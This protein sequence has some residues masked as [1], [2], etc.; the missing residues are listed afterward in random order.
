MAKVE[1]I[2]GELDVT[3]D[4][5]RLFPRA[6]VPSREMK[7]LIKALAKVRQMTD[8]LDNIHLVDPALESGVMY[9]ILD[10]MGDLGIYAGNL[11]GKVM[12]MQ[13]EDPKARAIKL[14]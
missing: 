9:A 8:Q 10:T 2:Y 11:K 4:G 14:A 6:Y 7:A 3:E 13:S 5:I 12:R 1:A